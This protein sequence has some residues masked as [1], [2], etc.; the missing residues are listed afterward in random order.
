MNKGRLEEV[1]E[2]CDPMGRQAVSIYMNPR[3]LS[4]TEPPTSHH[5]LAGLRPP[6][7]IQYRTAWSD[8]IVHIALEKFRAPG[9]G[10]AWWCGNVGTSCWRWR[11]RNGMGKCW[12]VEWERY[13]DWAVGIS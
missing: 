11:S 2:Q 9:S 10:E 5:T 13:S 7:H 6:T 8:L 3:N 1:E 4:G 12:R